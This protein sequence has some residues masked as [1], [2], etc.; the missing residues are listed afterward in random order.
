MTSGSACGSWDT[1]RYAS[2]TLCDDVRRRVALDGR[3]AVLLLACHLD[4]SGEEDDDGPD[5]Q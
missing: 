1:K 3:P 4:R 5:D 2:S